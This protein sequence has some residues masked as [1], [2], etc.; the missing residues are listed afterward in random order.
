M[1]NSGTGGR[2]T[3]ACLFIKV[4]TERERVGWSWRADAASLTSWN[5]IRLA[6]WI[7][8]WTKARR[9]SALKSNLFIKG[10]KN[11]G[12][13][14]REHARRGS[15]SWY[16]NRQSKLHPLF[17]RTDFAE[18]VKNDFGLQNLLI[19]TLSLWGTWRDHISCSFCGRGACSIASTWPS[20][21]EG[22]ADASMERRQ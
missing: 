1:E 20:A 16:W 6:S 22:D 9:T 8:K 5:E 3:L 10:R 18:V 2:S 7:R 17:Q 14:G 15:T 21:L 4:P 13:D 11:D 19:L 12:I